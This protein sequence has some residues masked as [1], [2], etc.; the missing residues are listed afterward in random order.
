MGKTEVMLGSQKGAWWR[1]CGEGRLD[2]LVR[3]QFALTST[4]LWKV[5]PGHYVQQGGPCEVFVNGQA[6]GLQRMPV[7]PRGWAKV[8]ATAV[9][10]PRYLEPVRSPR[11]K[12]IFSS[13]SNRGDI[14]VR[15]DVSLE[16][17]E[18]AVLLC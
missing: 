14:V 10:G 17:E 16:S 15:S 1:N 9:G 4:E 5:P 18:V 3:E 6:C 12:V 11:W 7:L 8:D 13:G 2:V